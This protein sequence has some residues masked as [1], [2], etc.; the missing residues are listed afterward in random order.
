M[1]LHVSGADRS[2]D[3][4]PFSLLLREGSPLH[5]ALRLSRGTLLLCLG[6]L[7]GLHRRMEPFVDPVVD[8]GLDGVDHIAD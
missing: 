7:L 3:I 2:D 6:G 5:L 8:V 1:G 4:E